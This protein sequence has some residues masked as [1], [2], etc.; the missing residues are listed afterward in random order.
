M[1]KKITFTFL[2]CCLLASCGKKGDPQYEDPEQKAEMIIILT[3][4]A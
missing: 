3:N 1:I 4:K 2:I